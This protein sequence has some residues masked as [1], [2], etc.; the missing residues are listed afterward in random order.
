MLTFLAAM[1]FV[2]FDNTDAPT[3]ISI[4]VVLA[5]LGVMIVLLLYLE[6]GNNVSGE[7]SYIRLFTFLRER[8]NSWWD[9]RKPQEDE[10]KK[11]WRDWIFRREPCKRHSMADT[12]STYLESIASSAS[13]K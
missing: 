13:E 6:R 5:V 9:S 1:M 12:E 10:Q 2:F 3:K 11:T 7:T 8:F 4:S